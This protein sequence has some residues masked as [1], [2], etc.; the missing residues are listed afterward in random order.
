MKVKVDCAE[1]NMPI[2]IE[3]TNDIIEL[4]PEAFNA[5]LNRLSDGSAYI[6]FYCAECFKNADDLDSFCR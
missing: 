3:I 2:V 1:C 6:E 5:K 4:K